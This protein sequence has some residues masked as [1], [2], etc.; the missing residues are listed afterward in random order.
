M[1][2]DQILIKFDIRMDDGIIMKKYV[3]AINGNTSVS[4]VVDNTRSGWIS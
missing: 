4:N 2:A 3:K 1:Q